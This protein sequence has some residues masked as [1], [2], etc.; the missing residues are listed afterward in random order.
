M[1]SCLFL[2]HLRYALSLGSAQAGLPEMRFAQITERLAQDL[3]KATSHQGL[4]WVYYLKSQ[5][6]HSRPPRTDSPFSLTR[7][8]FFP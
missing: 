3:S 5:A 4:L 7:F 1:Y 8:I 6:P 2:E